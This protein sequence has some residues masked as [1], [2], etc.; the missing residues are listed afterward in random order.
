MIV[1]V[2]SLMFNEKKKKTNLI[3]IKDFLEKNRDT[4][5]NDLKHVIAKSTNRLIKT[6]FPME[7]LNLVGFKNR[8]ESILRNEILVC[9]S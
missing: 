4:F 9:I 7:S 8:K 2:S 5:S 6:I 1:L 3:F